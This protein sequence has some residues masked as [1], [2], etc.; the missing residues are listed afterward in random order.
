MKLLLDT[1][2]FLEILLEQKNEREA[3][4]LLGRWEEHALFVTDFSVHSVGL[5]LF[6][7]GKH[8][9][10]RRFA[11]EV[12]LDQ[13]AFMIQL[14]CSDM[15]EVADNAERLGL[16]FDDAYQYAAAEQHGLTIV[17]YDPDFDS[18]PKG[19]KTPSE[20]LAL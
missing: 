14:G 7:R 5:K 18:T 10:F 6:E 20:I 15:K 8:D 2:I 1:N 13:I 19:R 11:K 16:D 4:E 17:S 12:L 9:D 3:R